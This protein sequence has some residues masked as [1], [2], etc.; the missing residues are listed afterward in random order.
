M[1]PNEPQVNEYDYYKSLYGDL[2]DEQLYIESRFKQAAQDH[3]QMVIEKTKQTSG[4]SETKVGRDLTTYKFTELAEEFKAFI[5]KTL[6]PKAGAKGTWVNCLKQIDASIEDRDAL[7]NLFAFATSSVVINALVGCDK[8]K[9]LVSNISLVLKDRFQAE[10]EYHDFLKFLKDNQ[11]EREYNIFTKG[12][13]KRVSPHYRRHYM[14][15]SMKKDNYTPKELIKEEANGLATQL[16]YVAQPILGYY[17]ISN[18]GA[19]NM[20]RLCPTQAYIEGWKR[21]E[22]HLIESA[23]RLCPTIIPPRPWTSYDDGGYYGDLAP[24][25]KLLRLSHYRSNIFHRQY[26]RRLSQADLSQVLKAVNGIQATPWKI[27]KQVLDVLNEIVKLGGN[28]AGLPNFDEDPKPVVLSENPTPEELAH[29]KEVMPDWYRAETRRKSLALRAL[30]H[31]N[32]A[33]EFCKYERIYFPSN[34][35]FRGRIYGCPQFNFQGDS[36]NKALILFADAPACEDLEDIKWLA[37][38]GAN[39]AGHDK[40]SYEDRIKWVHDNEENILLSAQ[41]P[42]GHLWWSNEENPCEFLAF[43]FEW[44]KWKLWEAEHNGDPKGFVTGLASH[45]DGTCSGLQHYS[46]ILRDKVAGVAVNLMPQ[47]KPNDIYSLVADEV[48]KLLKEDLQNGTADEY[49][50]EGKIKYGTKTM[51]QIWST[52]GVNRKVTK[53]PTMTL[54]YGAKEYGYRDQILDD[55]IDPAIRDQ[56]SGCVFNKHNKWKASAYMANLIWH[57][58]D[59]VVLKAC[60]G[61]AWLQQCAKASCKVGRPVTW[62]TPMGLPIQQEYLKVDY[63][64]MQMSVP[65]KRIRIYTP[66]VTGDVAKTSQTNGVA[67]N[68]IHSMDAAHL[69]LTINYCLDAGIKHFATIHDSYGTT[70]PDTKKMY[71]LVRQAMYDMYTENDVLLNFR[72]DIEDIVDQPLPNP[73]KKGDLNLSCILDSPYIFC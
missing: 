66:I 55:T 68:F 72:A 63:T 20:E 33:N 62:V 15:I 5:E 29:Y 50:E 16:L 59:K 61:M 26:M 60:E 24:I 12:L 3:L 7:A 64:V 48:N 2:Y 69:Q 4:A 27:N 17:T 43:C 65:G 41:D 70:I 6:R 53:R 71:K 49:T 54:A 19:K 52:F 40:I 13:E 36:L 42:L 32:I 51:A 28:I 34:M 39:I 9:L 30:S 56:G 45:Q 57:S 46:A 58:V 67:P 73:P 11:M 14:D 35:D 31:I 18:L 44:S 21:N 37:I 38:T 22:K 23:Y 1:C 25:N 8:E 47:D 10:Y